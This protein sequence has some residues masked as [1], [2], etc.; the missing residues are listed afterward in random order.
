M[1]VHTFTSSNYPLTTY[2]SIERS[3]EEGPFWVCALSIYQHSD[4]DKDV[5]IGDQLGLDPE[6]GPFT[7]I[8]REVGNN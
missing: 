4:P 2:I 3:K 7:T 1:K 8:L 6:Y 5:T